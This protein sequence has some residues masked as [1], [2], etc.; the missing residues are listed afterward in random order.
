LT[1]SSGDTPFI[2]LID[3]DLHSA[4]LLIRVLREHGAPHVR[5]L[6]GDVAG[7]AALQVHL[8]NFDITWP[9]LLIV[10]LKAHSQANADFIL[11]VQPLV[12]QKGV[13]V[14]AMSQ[15]LD[16][17]GRERLLQAGAQAVFWR[18]ADLDAYR[19]EAERIISFR[20]H[21]QRLDAVGM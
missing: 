14:V 7:R 13:P 8:S 3:D 5:H 16:S 4:R 9:D 19:R 1:A 6:G 10:D 21:N 11:S 15:P 18:E 17:Q 20:A 12:R 2:A